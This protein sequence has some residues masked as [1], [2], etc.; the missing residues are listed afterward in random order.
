MIQVYIGID[1]GKSGAMCVWRPYVPAI[2]ATTFILAG[3][4]IDILANC[5]WLDENIG[6]E[7]CVAYIEK[8][9][10]MPSQGVT[11]MFTF[12]FNTGVVH[13][14]IGSM[15]IPLHIVTP[16]QWK[17][18]ILAGTKKDK[19]AAIYYCR[20][21]YPQLSLLPTKRSKKLHSGMADAVCIARYG[22]EVHSIE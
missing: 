21:V 19:D 3:K 7:E 2:F 13:G 10:A 6:D 4:E 1:P 20:R 16:Q 11:S 14:I 18:K 12:G 9:H 17:S 8:V 22:Y 5:N 15:G